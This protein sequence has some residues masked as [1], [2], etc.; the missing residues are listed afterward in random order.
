MFAPE[1]TIVKTIWQSGPYGIDT[2]QYEIELGGGRRLNAGG[3]LCA[4]YT[5]G[6]GV[7]ASA[8]ETIRR[9]IQLA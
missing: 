6:Y 4:Y 3:V 2:P 5:H 8:D 7:T 1:A 9:S